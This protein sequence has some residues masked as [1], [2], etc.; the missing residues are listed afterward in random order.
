MGLKLSSR[1]NKKQQNTAKEYLSRAKT[2]VTEEL[3]ESQ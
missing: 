2:N 3:I 1:V